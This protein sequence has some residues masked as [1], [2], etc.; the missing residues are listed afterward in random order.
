[1]DA[2]VDADE[3]EDEKPECPTH[4]HPA[5]WPLMN[6]IYER[7]KD[8]S[9][10]QAYEVLIPVV[11]ERGAL[12]LLD[13]DGELVDENPWLD[14]FDALAS[15]ERVV[16]V[17][18]YQTLKT[19]REGESGD[20]RDVIL[21]ETPRLLA[22]EH[23]VSVEDLVR[24]ES[25]LDD[26]ADLRPR[27]DPLAHNFRE[28]ARFAARVR[29]A[30]VDDGPGALENVESPTLIWDRYESWDPAAGEYVE[31]VEP[32]EDWK[33]GE[34]AAQLKLAYNESTVRR[35]QDGEWNGEPFCMDSLLAAA[36]T[37]GLPDEDLRRA[38]AVP[39]TLDE[40]PW[41]ES[42][43]GFDNGARCCTVCGWHERDNGV[44]TND[45]EAARATAWLD[46]DPVTID[47]DEEP[48]LAFKS[49]PNT[50][51]LPTPLVLDATATPKKVA[52]FYGVP[53]ENVEV[54][55]D[56]PLD[57]DGK[58]RIT[59]VLDGQYHPGTIEDS[60][61][62]QRRIQNVADATG[63]FYDR[64]LFMRKKGHA[65]LFDFAENGEGLPPGGAR[66][67][68]RAG[69]DAVVSIGAP[70]LNGDDLRRDAE[71]LAM[72]RNDLDAGG[73][74]YSTRR[75]E[76]GELAAEPPIYRKLL[77]A[78]EN[79]EGRAV[80][81]KHYSGLMGALFYEGREKEIVQDVHRAR[82]L[83]V[84]PDEGEEPIDVFLLT[85]VPT[86]LPV[87]EVCAFDELADDLSAIFPVADGALD[88]LGAVRD[89]A[90]GDGP[91]G[92]R[93]NQLVEQRD[94]GTIANNR[95][96]LTELARLAG[97]TARG[98]DTPPS[99]ET[100]CEWVDQLEAVG[101]LTPGEYEQ[102]R[103]VVYEADPATL[104]SAL[105]LLSRNGF[106]KVAAVRRFREKVARS[107]GSLGWL[108]WAEAV[109]DLGG[110]RCEW[111]PPPTSGT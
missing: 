38:V 78:D 82:P 19:V 94:D 80:P 46:D 13:E 48:A 87:D 21:D 51:D 63:E 79:G 74:E 65:R 101:L 58:V 30:I 27:D 103:G 95:R 93:A 100:V 85:N 102:R 25:R 47:R 33:V 14:Q 89:V 91:D 42:D 32:D 98:K 39:S 45:G 23:R 57:L 75:G 97:V 17:H 81:T 4:G 24:V 105:Q 60:E 67:L 92:F 83:L 110:N 36:A 99:Y 3:D 12:F 107:D 31:D 18:E 62:A 26:L 40:C 6:P 109:F 10:R 2:A 37:A 61:T 22:S 1:M 50:G 53:V 16:G 11:G 77:Y 111:D 49:L 76:D 70:H 68:N 28:L 35:V 20:E 9:V 96:G 73:V 64:P 104:D 8:D 84:D 69:C 29:D 7:D 66:G 56:A 52:A 34:A 108:A 54:E 86:D 59:Q 55:G 41:C 43:L 90:A 106:S 72:D 44:T 71:L 15:A 88:L 5:A